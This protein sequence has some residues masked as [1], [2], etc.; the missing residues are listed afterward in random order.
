MTRSVATGHVF[1]GV[2]WIAAILLGVLDVI[3]AGHYGPL[4]VVA[5]VAA[6]TLHVRCWLAQT[7]QHSREWYEL[8]KAAATQ[9]PRG[10]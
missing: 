10:I 5:A 4:G 2:F 7:E 9:R 1:A 6:G 3:Y 8:G